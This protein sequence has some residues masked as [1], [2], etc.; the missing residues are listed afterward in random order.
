MVVWLIFIINFKLKGPITFFHKAL[1][2]LL[3]IVEGWNSKI[4]RIL[5]Y[6]LRL[7]IDLI[8]KTNL[9][10]LFFW[11]HFPLCPLGWIE[12][13]LFKLPKHDSNWYGTRT[14]LTKNEPPRPK[15]SIRD[16]WIT[17]FGLNLRFSK[18]NFY[19]FIFLKTWTGQFLL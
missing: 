5:T 13:L 14:L 15:K 2:W 12:L 10:F 16:R 11:G 17:F 6:I 3:I 9:I 1:I 18:M 8:S 4:I 7:S 19:P